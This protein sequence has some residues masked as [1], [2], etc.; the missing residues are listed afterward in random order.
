MT[1]TVARAIATAALAAGV[2]A[3]V[4]APAMAARSF[5]SCRAMHRVYPHGVGKPYA[6]D[7]TYGTPVTN[8]KRSLPLYRA[9][10]SLDRD[11]DGIA[12]EHH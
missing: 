12:C 5:S 6:Y 3:A 1:R 4:P 11:H 2:M 9:N 7:F 10:K 8:F